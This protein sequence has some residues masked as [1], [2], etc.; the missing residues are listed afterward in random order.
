MFSLPFSVAPEQTTT[1][2]EECLLKEFS[3]NLVSV[4]W[5]VQQ[6]DAVKWMPVSMMMM[7]MMMMMMILLLLAAD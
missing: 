7:M 5:K 6:L 2:H 4:G 3:M 1:A